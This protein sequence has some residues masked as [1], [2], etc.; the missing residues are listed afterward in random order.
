LDWKLGMNSHRRNKEKRRFRKG[1]PVS[2][3]CGREK[4]LI[5]PYGIKVFESSLLSKNGKPQ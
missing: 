2:L 3:K 1:L 5:I 4:K